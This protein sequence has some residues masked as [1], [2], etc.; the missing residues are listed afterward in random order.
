MSAYVFK[1]AFVTPQEHL[2]LIVKAKR[3]LKI[4]KTC[5]KW[6]CISNFDKEKLYFFS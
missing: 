4:V 6:T 5:M 2:K 3:R 1:K